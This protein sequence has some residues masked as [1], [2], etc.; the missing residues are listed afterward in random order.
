MIST[1][2]L[3]TVYL[4]DLRPLPV[5]LLWIVL[6]F[7]GLAARGHRSVRFWVYCERPLTCGPSRR[8]ADRSRRRRR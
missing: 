1:A 2:N 8:L 5:E 7:S 4:G 3:V 6:E